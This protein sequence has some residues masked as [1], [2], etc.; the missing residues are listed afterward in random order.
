MIKYKQYYY[1]IDLS[2]PVLYWN[3]ITLD[4]FVKSIN[5]IKIDKVNFSKLNMKFVNEDL[6]KFKKKTMNKI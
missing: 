4:N 1:T 3:N 6:E 5:T 2:V